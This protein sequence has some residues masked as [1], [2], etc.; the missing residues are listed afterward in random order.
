MGGGVKFL[1]G[2]ES[3]A[4]SQLGRQDDGRGKG[5][6]GGLLQVADGGGA[7]LQ[8]V[9]GRPGPRHGVVE[10]RQLFGELVGGIDRFAVDGQQSVALPDAQFGRRAARDD[11]IDRRRHERTAEHGRRFQHFEQVDL[12]RQRH[13]GG[14]SV[15]DDIDKPCLG[16][17][18]EE[19][20]VEVLERSSVCSDEDVAVLEAHAF[21]LLVELHAHLHVLHAHIVLAPSEHNHGVDEQRQQE[22]DQHAAC[23]DEQTLPRRLRAKLPWLLGLLHLFGV[24]ALVYHAGNLAIAAE[25]QP[26]KAVG[27]VTVLGFELEKMEPGVEEE[28]EFLY[29]DT[30]ELGEEEVASFVE[31]HQERD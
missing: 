21:G 4:Q 16:N 3:H 15:A 31:E 13:A 24:H 28:V 27:R 23:H 30:K 7:Y 10:T 18:A 26:A 11:R 19:V 8:A 25:G 6:A 14:L 17:A 29:S 1:Y 12:A 22:I 5:V 20:G 9:G 2:R